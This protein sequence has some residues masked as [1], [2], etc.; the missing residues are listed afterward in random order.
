LSNHKTSEEKIYFFETQDVSLEDFQHEGWILDIGGGGEGIIGRLKGDAVVAVDPSRRELEEAPPGPLKIVMDA[1]ELN[2]LDE[3]FATVTSFFTM[4]YI[5]GPDH[6][7]V[8]Q[9]VF[10]VLKNGGKFLIWDGVLPVQLDDDKEIA[11]FLLRVKLP[12]EVVK[13]GY[14]TKWPT[15]EQNLEYYM[16]IARTTGFEIVE[17]AEDDRM[18]F[19]KL[20][21]PNK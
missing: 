20:R 4:M 5:A 21:K 12:D 16:S 18:L 13:T 7:K 2:F 8:F 9:E 11:A 10:R 6:A 3:A 17:T 15:S 19:M 14:G 1:R